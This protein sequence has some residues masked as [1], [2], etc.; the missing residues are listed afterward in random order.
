MFLRKLNVNLVETDIP[1]FKSNYNLYV[2]RNLFLTVNA[3]VPDPWSGDA[4]KIRLFQDRSTKSF[5]LG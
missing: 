2:S 4:D 1:I 3:F 5:T